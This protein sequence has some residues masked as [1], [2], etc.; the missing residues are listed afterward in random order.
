[1]IP[2]GEVDNSEELACEIGYKV[3]KLPTS[4]LGLP[5]GASYKSVVV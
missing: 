5:L 2:V 3:R 1:M 4:Y